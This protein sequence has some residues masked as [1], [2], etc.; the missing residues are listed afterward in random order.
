MAAIVPAGSARKQQARGDRILFSTSDD[1]VMMEQIL[2]THTPDGREFYIKPIPLIIEDIMHRANAPLPGA[3]LS[4]TS[5]LYCK[6]SGEGNAQATPLSLFKILSRYPWEVKVVVALAAFAMIYDEFQLVAQLYPT[7]PLAK[8]VADLK[9]LPDIMERAES[10]EPMFQSLVSL[11]KAVLDL[12]KC[13]V[14]FKSL[15]SQYIS[16][17]TPEMVTVTAHIPI[18]V[19]WTIRSIV[20]CASIVMNLIGISQEYIVLTTEAWELYSLSLKV[21]NIHTH[22]NKQLSLCHQHIAYRTLVWLFETPQ[23][24]NIKVL[25]AL[26][27]PKD[28]QLPLFESSTKRRVSIDALR[29]KVV[30]LFISE[31]DFSQEE[32]SLFDA[33]YRESMQNPSRPEG[34]QQVVWLPITDR[35]IPWNEEKQQQFVKSQNTMPWLSLHH[36]SVLDTAAIKYIKDYWHFTKKPI[37]VV[38][39]QQGKVVNLNALHMMWIWGT[40][41]YPYTSSREEQL[42]KEEAWRI[43]L[44]AHSIDPVIFDWICKGKHICLYGGENIDWIRKFT[45]TLRSVARG[46][47]IQLEMLYVGKSNPGNKIRKII[48]TIHAENLSRVWEDL[49]II[50]FFWSRLDSMWNSK[51]RLGKSVESDEIM[52]EIMIMLCFDNSVQGWAVISQGTGEM[53]KAKGERFL[54]SLYRFNEWK[55]QSDEKG[56]VPALNEFIQKLRTP[57]HCDRFVLSESTERVQDVVVCAECGRAMEKCIMYRCC[58]E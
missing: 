1:N 38:L 25:K 32:L 6:C 54:T 28:D 57:D 58:N 26:I 9:Q 11:I 23:T 2:S 48:T 18:A 41:A 14:E 4:A 53:A 42:W 19:F 3:L 34:H 49:T 40:G 31:L 35:S 8:S 47:N 17:D 24:D 50:W 30:L 45:T 43:E 36:P 44:L 51:V 10:L 16:P 37:V 13:I 21:N 22:F 39:D 27:N 52:K 12:T 20:A 5:Q 33:M 55:H 7:N 46:A 29:R 56:F 15:P